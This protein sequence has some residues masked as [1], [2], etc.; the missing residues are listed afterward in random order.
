MQYQVLDYSSL[1]Y[2]V[3]R[4]NSELKYGWKCQGGVSVHIQPDGF[5]LYL[6]AM[7]KE[8]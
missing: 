7:I 3:D 8:E 1:S 5:A 6:Q 2:L 4:I